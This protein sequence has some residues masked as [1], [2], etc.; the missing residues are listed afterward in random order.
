MGYLSEWIGIRS[1]YS[2]CRS[3]WEPHLNHCCE[4]IVRHLREHPEIR[5][6]A[7]CGSGWGLDLPW[8]SPEFQRLDKI[9]LLD[10]IHPWFI[11][12]RSLFQNNLKLIVHDLSGVISQVDA[13]E[14]FPEPI[15]DLKLKV[16]LV[17]SLNLIGQLPL[18]PLEIMEKRIH[19]SFEEELHEWARKIQ[20]KHLEALKEW[21]PRQIVIS[22]IDEIWRNLSGQ[23]V[24]RSDPWYGS[25][26]FEMDEQWNWD[27][28]PLGEMEKTRSKHHV[29]GVKVFS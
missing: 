11:R 10:L 12:W 25:R 24:D 6:V 1:R 27:I 28:S 26:D 29:V 17:V 20:R 2:R 14:R 8:K 16:D 21:A 4:V 7:F 9:I 22:D 13:G 5:S 19:P 15:I 23:I 3:L 18:M